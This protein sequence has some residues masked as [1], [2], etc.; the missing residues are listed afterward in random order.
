MLMFGLN[1]ASEISLSNKFA[2]HLI[3]KKNTIFKIKTFSFQINK[4]I[5]CLTLDRAKDGWFDVSAFPVGSV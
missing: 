1:D 5:I 4:M 2:L 3:E